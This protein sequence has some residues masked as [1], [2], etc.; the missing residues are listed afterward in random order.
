MAAGG[1][2]ILRRDGAIPADAP[3]RQRFGIAGEDLSGEDGSDRVPA[4]KQ[5]NRGVS[6]ARGVMDA[7]YLAGGER[8]REGTAGGQRGQAEG[9]GRTQRGGTFAEQVP[10]RLRVVD[11][12]QNLAV[13]VHE[14]DSQS[15]GD[16]VADQNL[17][18]A[19]GIE[20]FSPE[21]F[22]FKRRVQFEIG[23][24][25]VGNRG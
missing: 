19:R 22:Q 20:Q 17:R 14:C 5:G 24:V 13:V 21:R 23:L 7:D 6:H 18:P 16:A 4:Q 25:S 2:D 10:D 3:E 8:I 15:G 11:R 1:P 9:T 12:S